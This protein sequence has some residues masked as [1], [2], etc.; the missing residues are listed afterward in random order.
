MITAEEQRKRHKARWAMIQQC[1]SI[2]V[3]EDEE[4]FRTWLEGEFGTKRTS[5]LTEKQTIRFYLWLKHFTTGS[6]P[7]PVNGGWRLSKRKVWK[8]DQLRT[9]LK[10]DMKELYD[11]TDRQ[12][13][14]PK[15]YT[16]LTESE[17]SKVITGMQ[18]II[19]HRNKK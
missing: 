8:I 16:S 9:Q 19:K 2:G 15:L 12:I 3:W 11:F 5:K 4:H 14:S 18:A 7:P 6:K 13:G 10:W 17:A 1:F